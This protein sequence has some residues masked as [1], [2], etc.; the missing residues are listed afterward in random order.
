MTC[1]A[2]SSTPAAELGAMFD[3]IIRGANIIDGS[4][5][6]AYT[7]DLAIDGG[8]IA[9]VGAL[10]G[11][12]AA[13]VIEA[14]GRCLTPGFIDIHRH[15]DAA[16]FRPGWGRAELAQGLTTIIN[17][18]CGLSLAPVRGEHREALLRYLSPIVG[19]L[20]EGRDFPTME[21]YLRQAQEARPPINT[22]MLAGMG[23]IRACAAGFSNAPLTEAEYAKVHALLEESLAG[24]AVG[25]SLGLG[26]APECFYDTAGLIRALEP[27]RNGRT[28]VSVHMRQE[29][30]GVVEALREMLA[31]ARE[32]RFPL[33]ISHLKAIG[34]RN[35]R[36]AVPEMLR[37]I[38]GARQEGLEVTCDVYPYPAGSTQLI[39]V[40]PPEFQAGGAEALTRALEDP[41]QRARMRERME[42]GEDFENI[43]LLV[44][45]ENIRATSLHRPENRPFEGSSI[46]EIAA[47]RGQEPF[48]ALF[49]LLASEHCAVSMIDF[50]A[51]EEDICDILRAPFSGV[52]SD[53]TYPV[54]GLLH[55]RVYGTFPR[56]IE[57]YVLEKGV[58]SL[59]EAVRKVTRRPAELYGLAGKGRIEP[60]ADADLCLFAP[61]NIHERDSYEHPE[62]LASGMDWVF[63][64]GRPAIEE[65]EFTTQP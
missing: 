38:D 52:I 11:A 50:I 24:G 14:R 28:V 2:A 31:V 3:Y 15:A 54:G 9:A 43:S 8:R 23:S 34:R 7:A 62:R 39:H 21:A 32:L 41:A 49:D 27:L 36:L 37:L 65:G 40:L 6:P 42:S 13:R 26:Y 25:V 33:E 18:N 44:G 19:E 63:V 20:P 46:A 12:G 16:L 17:G 60:G 53:A 58:L 64:S 59:P 45:F 35:W 22:L 51:H 57:R 29:G 55:P 61:E 30:D 1:A 48:D 10:D 47:A 56:L 4:G 5:G